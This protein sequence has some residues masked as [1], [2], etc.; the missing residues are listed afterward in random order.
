MIQNPEIKRL[1][2]EAR[3]INKQI[4][5]KHKEN[6][7]AQEKL[8]KDGSRRENSKK[9]RL[10]AEIKKL[11]ERHKQLLEEKKELPEKVDVSNLEDYRS[12]NKIDNEGKNLFDLGASRLT[13]KSIGKVFPVNTNNYKFYVPA[14]FC[15]VLF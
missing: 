14:L 11:E 3:E 15:N 4:N 6:S 5:K 8:N 13:P 7:K 1:E 9:A 2:K 10:E 12:F